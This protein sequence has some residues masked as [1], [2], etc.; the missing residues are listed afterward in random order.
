VFEKFGSILAVAVAGAGGTCG[1]PN[2]ALSSASKQK[3]NPPC[4]PSAFAYRP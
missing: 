2:C 4:G 1:W 3:A